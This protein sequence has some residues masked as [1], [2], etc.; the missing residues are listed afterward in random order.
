MAPGEVPMTTAPELASRQVREC[1]KS[2]TPITKTSA[3][4][5]QLRGW[6]VPLAA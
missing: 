2:R 5:L 1:D 6:S 4:P 3:L